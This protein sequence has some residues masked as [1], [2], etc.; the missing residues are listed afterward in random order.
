MCISCAV[1]VPVAV[2]LLNVGEDVVDKAWGIEPLI[3][4]LS[5]ERIIAAFEPSEPLMSDAICTELDTSVLL[6]VPPSTK[7]IL[8]PRLELTV[9]NEPLIATPKLEDISAAIILPSS[10]FEAFTVIGSELCGLPM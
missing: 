8:E 3:V 6:V 9:V 4:V 7:V 1:S 10:I 2:M 5:S